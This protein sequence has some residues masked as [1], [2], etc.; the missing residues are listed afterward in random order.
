MSGL[1]QVVVS[2]QSGGGPAR[3]ASTGRFVRGEGDFQGPA[4]YA[5]APV[6][7]EGELTA[8]DRAPER[9]AAPRDRQ[10]ARQSA[11]REVEAGGESELDED[12]RIA[13]QELPEGEVASEHSLAF[14]SRSTPAQES[15]DQADSDD[16]IQTPRPVSRVEAHAPTVADATQQQL[17]A[18]LDRM[19]RA[20]EQ[21]VAQASRQQ[22][23][24]RAPSILE[25][26]KSDPAFLSKYMYELSMGNLNPD[27]PEHRAMAIMAA[28]MA[29]QHE[30]AKEATARELRQLQQ[31]REELTQAAQLQNSRAVAAQ[32]IAAQVAGT[33]LAEDAEALAHLAGQVAP[34]VAQGHDPKQVVAQALGPLAKHLIRGKSGPAAGKPGEAGRLRQPTPEQNSAMRSVAS[35]GKATGRPGDRGPRMDFA[36]AMKVLAATERHGP[37]YSDE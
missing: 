32:A 35:G 22:E 36:K 34:W 1:A 16:Q 20:E 2:E 19:T 18:L 7:Y 10:S 26:V 3:D 13:L 11:E 8:D 25:R 33:S 15:Q 6:K 27:I 14:R 28:S 29:D 12:T 37:S 21:R 31:F 17:L 9:V 5:G 30:A 24:K 4:Q 23:E